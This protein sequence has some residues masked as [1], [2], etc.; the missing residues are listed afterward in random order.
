MSRHS[1]DRKRRMSR[2]NPRIPKAPGRT[3]DQSR[4]LRGLIDEEIGDAPGAA[5]GMIGDLSEKLGPKGRFLV[6]ATVIA[7]LI[8]GGSLMYERYTTTVATSADFSNPAQTGLG[9]TLYDQHCAYC[10]GK[11]LGGQPGW[12]GS[13]PNGKR[14]AL[15]LDGRGPIAR[16]S[17]R[18][19]FDLVKFGGQPF[20]PAGYVN[21]MPGY[22]GQLADA[23]IWAILAYLKSRWSP[24]TLA[25]QKEITEAQGG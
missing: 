5:S 4:R 12:D 1:F 21:Q 11:D 10:H 25:R 16:L 19:L 20:S 13:F 17:D 23:D 14:P 3:L 8:T 6:A 18:D 2:I 7:A 22:T 9:H 15:P 24:E